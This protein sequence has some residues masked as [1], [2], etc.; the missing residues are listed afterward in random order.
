MRLANMVYFG[1][2]LH[3]HFWSIFPSWIV[4]KTEKHVYY[5]IGWWFLFAEFVTTEAKEIDDPI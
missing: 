2:Y 4:D 1:V 3:P 5:H